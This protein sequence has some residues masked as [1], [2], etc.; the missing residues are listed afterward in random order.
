MTTTKTGDQAAAN[1]EEL[2]QGSDEHMGAVEG[3]RT[4]DKVNEGNPNGTGVDS[5][6]MPNDPVAT[7]EDRLGAIADGSEGG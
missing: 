7:A 6:G 2:P 4:D 5:N 3:D 1:P